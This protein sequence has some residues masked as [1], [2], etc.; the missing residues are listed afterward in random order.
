MLNAQAKSD[1]AA[2]RYPDVT[3]VILA[4]GQSRRMG[5]DKATLT[6]G[7]TTLF[8]R[9]LAVMR[10]IFPALLIAGDRPDLARPDVPC[11]PDL[12]PG[13]ALGGLYTGLR[14][15]KT[16]YIFAVACDMP[17]ADPRLIRAILER[18]A[19]RDLVVPET[20]AGLE[21]LFALYGKSCLEPMRGLL[22]AGN[23]RIY[24]FFPRVRVCPVGPTELPAGWER[25]LLNLNTP[26]E[27]LRLQEHLP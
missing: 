1:G 13:S 15:A 7:G 5:R 21:P 17:F 4:G 9:L 19:G 18:R 16:P 8:A 20:P 3:G 24:D 27:F 26:E 14:A 6:V 25:A 22:E 23:Y 12:Y 2:A 10:G 11:L